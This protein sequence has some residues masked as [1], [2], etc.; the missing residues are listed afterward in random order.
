MYRWFLARFQA[1]VLRMIPS[2]FFVVFPD[3]QSSVLK[4][5]D[6]GAAVGRFGKLLLGVGDC[7]PRWFDIL[8]VLARMC[9]QVKTGNH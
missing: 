5:R 3:V 1:T 2:R 4:N 9:N 8:A 6:H 7:S